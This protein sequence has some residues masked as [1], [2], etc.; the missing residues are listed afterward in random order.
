MLGVHDMKHRGVTVVGSRSTPPNVCT[1]ISWLAFEFTRNGL[2]VRSGHVE[3]AD[4]AAEQGACQA[5]DPDCKKR[6][7]D[8]VQPAI[9]LPWERFCAERA[10]LGRAVVVKSSFIADQLVRDHHPAADLLTA[11]AFSLHRRNGAQ[12]LGDTFDDPS[13]AVVCWRDPAAKTSGTDQAMRIARA[14][15]VPVFNLAL[16]VDCVEGVPSDGDLGVTCRMVLAAVLRLA[17]EPPPTPPAPL[18][19]K[20]SLF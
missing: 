1:Q 15:G 19:K 11:G 9:Y 7:V 3:G 6:G 14:Y 5:T 13:V 2:E 12:V 16:G 18:D 4:W 20:L 10:V 8:P 17:K